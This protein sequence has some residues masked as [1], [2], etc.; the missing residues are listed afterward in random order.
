[1]FD[2]E[3]AWQISDVLTLIGWPVTFAL[4]IVATV[5]AQRILR[6]KAVVS[7][8]VASETTL[9]PAELSTD[10]GMN[11]EMTVGGYSPK[12]LSVATLLVGSAGNQTIHDL[13]LS[14][15]LGEGTVLRFDSARPLGAYG[16]HVNWSFSERT[17][18]IKFD[19]LNPEHTRLEFAMVLGDYKPGGL[20]VDM[21]APG[22]RLQRREAANWSP[23]SA[24]LRNIGLNPFGVRYDPSIAC[25]AEIAAALRSL[26][27][28]DFRAESK[29]SP[30]LEAEHRDGQ[31]TEGTQL[32]P[33]EKK[34]ANAHQP[35]D[36]PLLSVE[37]RHAD[38]WSDDDARRQT[39]TPPRVRM[40]I[41][42]RNIGRS[43]VQVRFARLVWRRRD[44]H[45]H[46]F[47]ADLPSHSQVRLR[48][49]IAPDDETMLDVDLARD[50]SPPLH[51]RDLELLVT[52]EAESL[53]E[54]V[55][56]SEDFSVISP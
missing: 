47:R 29:Q 36:R 19:F 24:I 35:K 28:L 3:S 38:T 4:G 13:E 22:V 44:D 5:V 41:A 30:T 10:L 31:R 46:V 25:L 23:Y 34:P 55:I 54:G 49:R 16:K 27:V 26:K 1:M 37:F 40:R 8:S 12:S 7:W 39:P 14:I 52:A 15:D 9:I 56:G 18:A 32:P 17:I 43:P 11:V 6:K 42:C 53:P 51:L 50:A 20:K 45:A 48:G 33:L 21:A 2:G